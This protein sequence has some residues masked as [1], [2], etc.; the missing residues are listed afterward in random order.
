MNRDPYKYSQGYPDRF[1]L[2]S[3][4]GDVSRGRRPVEVALPRDR[5]LLVGAPRKGTRDA[6]EVEE[7]LDELA[8]LADTAGAGVVG[9][10]V[11]IMAAPAPPMPVS[12]VCLMR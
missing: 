10:V 1:R 4:P 11:Q 8:C 5:V 3:F 9:R 2:P 12:L 7:H 6:A